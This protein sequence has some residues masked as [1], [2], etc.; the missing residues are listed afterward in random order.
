MLNCITDKQ[1]TNEHAVSNGLHLICICDDY[2]KKKEER[3]KL[4]A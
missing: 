2:L 3:R 1:L 4:S